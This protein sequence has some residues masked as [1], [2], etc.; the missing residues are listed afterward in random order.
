MH[1]AH[2]PDVKQCILK[3]NLETIRPLAQKML[4]INDPI[5]LL[6]LLERINA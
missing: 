3:S 6:L 4:R 2:L 1:S 5:K